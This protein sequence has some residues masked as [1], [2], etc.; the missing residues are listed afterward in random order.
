MP[1]DECHN[2]LLVYTYIFIPIQLLTINFSVFNLPVFYII[3]KCNYEKILFSSLI[4]RV[5]N[6]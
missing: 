3:S 1:F 2:N 6:C 5:D 4:A